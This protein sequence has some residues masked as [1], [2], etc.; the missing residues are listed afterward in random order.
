MMQRKFTPGMK[1][2]HLFRGPCTVVRE[3]TTLIGW[4]V[5]IIKDSKGQIYDVN[6][7]YLREIKEVHDERI[8]SKRT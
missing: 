2:E 7:I 6:P 5:V 3:S 1:V 4:P 8:A